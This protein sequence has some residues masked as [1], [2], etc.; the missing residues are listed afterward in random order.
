MV[1]S[2]GRLMLT[3]SINLSIDFFIP[4]QCYPQGR[5]VFHCLNKNRYLILNNFHIE[6]LLSNEFTPNLGNNLEI[7]FD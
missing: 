5:L 1:A 3:L 7:I 2:H 6:K 4:R